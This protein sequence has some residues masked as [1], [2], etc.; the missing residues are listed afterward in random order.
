M[1]LAAAPKLSSPTTRTTRSTRA[2]RF[3][4]TERS[5]LCLLLEE[6]MFP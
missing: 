4:E 5:L 3:C 2:S 6:T 1:G